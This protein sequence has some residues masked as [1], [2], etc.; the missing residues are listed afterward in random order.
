MD[1]S[2]SSV[3]HVLTCLTWTFFCHEVP[4]SN[5]LPLSLSPPVILGCAPLSFSGLVFSAVSLSSD[6]RLY[7][8]LIHAGFSRSAVVVGSGRS[9]ALAALLPNSEGALFTSQSG[10]FFSFPSVLLVRVLSFAARQSK[11]F[12]RP[13]YQSS[14]KERPHLN[15]AF[16][17]RRGLF[18][19]VC[20][21]TSAKNSPLSVHAP[22]YY[23]Q[24]A[25][26]LPVCPSLFLLYCILFLRVTSGRSEVAYSSHDMNPKG[27]TALST[28]TGSCRERGR[29]T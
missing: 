6:I 13:S 8:R 25:R 29:Y 28:V 22:P 15:R 27:L 9:K 23:E 20:T 11:T 24:G 5:T 16:F 26:C 10:V 21:L 17:F 7:T 1:S 2:L 18:A 4:L 19:S 3:S 12:L 14:A